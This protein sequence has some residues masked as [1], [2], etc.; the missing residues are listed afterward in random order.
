MP[1]QLEY[2][3]AKLPKLEAEA[4]PDN[5]YVKGLKAQIARLE[6]PPA[7]N[8]MDSQERLTLGMRGPPTKS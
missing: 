5:P 2:L 4:G 3:K 6:K 7:E 1:S 8:P